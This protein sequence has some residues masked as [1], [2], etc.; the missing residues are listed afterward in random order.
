MNNNDRKIVKKLKKDLVRARVKLTRI[1]GKIDAA[2]L[3]QD[4][5][6]D[7]RISEIRDVELNL[8]LHMIRQD[9]E[10]AITATNSLEKKLAIA[11]RLVRAKLEKNEVLTRTIFHARVDDSDDDDDD[12]DEE[13]EDGEPIPKRCHIGT[14][15]TS[16]TTTTTTTTASTSST[17]SPPPR[18]EFVAVTLPTPPPPPPAEEPP[19]LFRYRPI[20]PH[21]PPESPSR[22]PSPSESMMF[23]FKQEK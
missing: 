13:E 20:A 22:F 14:V 11:H 7:D 8:L 4:F 19:A 21:P 1:Q 15:D 2:N 5:L 3:A 17:N 12:D 9:M 10:R 16:A 6:T 18:R 23:F